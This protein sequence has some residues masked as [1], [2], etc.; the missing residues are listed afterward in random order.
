[1]LYSSFLVDVLP[2]AMAGVEK[3]DVLDWQRRI[4][5]NAEML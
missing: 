2:Q 3:H 4:L 5:A 1:M